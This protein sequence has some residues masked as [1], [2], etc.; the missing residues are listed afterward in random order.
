MHF[1]HPVRMMLSDLNNKILLDSIKRLLRRGA[2]A[3]L[4]NIINKSHAADLSVVFR[5]LSHSDRLRLFNLLQDIE[6]KGLL[7]SELEEDIFLDLVQE[8]KTISEREKGLGERLSFKSAKKAGVAAIAASA[9]LSQMMYQK[10][11]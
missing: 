3:R 1:P 7:F 6:Q 2:A 8:M 11:Q 4:K 5:S 9:V 10:K